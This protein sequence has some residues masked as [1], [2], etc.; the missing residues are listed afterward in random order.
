M[1]TPHAIIL[2]LCLLTPAPLLPS[3]RPNILWITSEDNGI[4]WVGCYGSKNTK[5]AYHLS[6]RERADEACDMVRGMRDKRYAYIKNYMPWTP[7]GQRLKYMWVMKATQAW[8]K[9]YLEGKTN[10]VT[11]RFFRPRVSEEFYRGIGLSTNLRQG[12][13]FHHC[14]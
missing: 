2:L 9:H 7:N 12:F 4:S 14:A 3:E 13:R 1:K 10:E 8:E 6:F 11:G 5:P